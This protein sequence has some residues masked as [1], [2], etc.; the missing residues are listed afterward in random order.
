MVFFFGEWWFTS[1]WTWELGIRLRFSIS[2]IF[3]PG[4]YYQVI[5]RIENATKNTGLFQGH[6]FDPIFGSKKPCFHFTG[7]PSSMGHGATIA[8]FSWRGTTRMGSAH[9][10]F[11]FVR[12]LSQDGTIKSPWNHHMILRM[13]PGF[14]LIVPLLWLA[15]LFSWSIKWLNPFFGSAPQPQYVDEAPVFGPITRQ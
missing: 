15:M 6:S 5:P 4:P 14:V 11:P 1:Q 3:G 13:S 8:L 10:D 9:P 12:L 2:H 7:C